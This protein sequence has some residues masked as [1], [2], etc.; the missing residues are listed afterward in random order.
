MKLRT[1][2]LLIILPIWV[3][4]LV[5]FNIFGTY[6]L[7]KDVEQNLNK[8]LRNVA[9]FASDRVSSTVTDAAGQLEV[10][11]GFNI[12][13]EYMDLQ[14][15]KLRSEEELKRKEIEKIFN[16][17]LQNKR[18]YLGLQF[19][20]PKDNPIV[21]AVSPYHKIYG[22][23]QKQPS[24][25]IKA[26][27]NRNTE[28]SEAYLNPVFNEQTIYI[29]Y[30][31]TG[32]GFNSGRIVLGISLNKLLETFSE[33]RLLKDADVQI[34]SERFGKILP[35]SKL[36][37]SI[38]NRARNYIESDKM[39][40]PF[41]RWKLSLVI[42]KTDALSSM[43]EF[44]STNYILVAIFVMSIFILMWFLSRNIS[45]PAESLILCI[46]NMDESRHGVAEKIGVTL[47]GHGQ[48]FEAIAN[49]LDKMVEESSQNNKKLREL[50]V[51]ESIANISAQV[52]HD[53]R[54]PLAALDAVTK[55]VAR[56]PEEKRIIIRSA[57]GRIHD[58]ANNLLEKYRSVAKTTSAD[59]N[60]SATNATE[61]AGVYLLSSLIDP[62]ISEKRLQ[63]RSKIGVEIDAQLGT[64]SY[65]LFAKIQPTE[66]KRVISNLVNNSVEVLDKNGSIIV[67]MSHEDGKIVIKVRD[68]GKGISSEILAKLGQRG[69]THGKIGGSGLGLYHARTSVESWDGTLKIESEAGNGTT[70][71]LTLP[72]AQPPDWFV[73][74]LELRPR[75]TIVILDD[76]TSIHQVWQGRFESLR[77][78][79]HGIE[80]LHFS[81]PEEFRGWVTNNTVASQAA[82]YLTDYELLGYKE[83]GL[84]L[85]E[86]LNLGPQAILVT[87][88]YEEQQVLDNCLRLKVRM[89]PK[90]LAG[91]V[92]IGITAP[93]AQTTGISDGKSPVAG[94]VPQ[95]ASAVLIDD[96]M[97]VH[98]TW[99]M[100]AEANGISLKAFK[101]PKEFLK[102][103]AILPKSTPIYIDAELGNDIN[104]EDI[105]KDLHAKG[106]TNLTLSTGHAPEEFAC[107]P[108]WLKII[109][110]EPPFGAGSSK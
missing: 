93:A 80:T 59:S 37:N 41:I 76:D 98:M 25:L 7:N 97:L 65:G 38:Y 103:I 101:E 50:A 68:T 46:R 51:L 34:Y 16:N 61:P 73:S 104:G 109:G 85:V 66:F 33:F 15:Y 84:S 5:L 29:S 39:D 69:E 30:Q 1:K 91:L 106:F 94:N 26:K 92:P 64:S 83:T 23:I 20:D 88:R 43:S 81:A 102:T 79:E 95:P 12:F 74:R 14:S 86:E 22:N 9:I 13:N 108:P 70:V 53:I 31:L 18:E 52:A 55:D 4:S 17:L 11:G 6:Y 57:I 48:E 96:D 71:T 105:A 63:F 62:L 99:E 78:K 19:M 67:E 45:K 10:L 56:L 77:A 107:L 87:S 8:E 35:I 47:R 58:I 42:S 40:I 54:S 28:I 27:Y 110:K 90:G 21:T 32:Q 89:I 36:N 60:G 82:L 49:A 44:E 3:A 100:V 72:A 2:I 75:S 24:D